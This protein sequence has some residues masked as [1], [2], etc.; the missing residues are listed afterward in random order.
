LTPHQIALIAIFAAFYVILSLITPIVLVAIGI[1]QLTISIEAFIASIFGLVLGP[2]LGFYAAFAGTSI[3]WILGGGSPYGL[4]FLLSPPFNALVTGFIYYRKW[5]QAFVILGILTAVFLFLPP[6][7]PFAEFWYISALV[8]W[9][10]II[11]LLLIIPT[12]KF[13]KRLSSTKLIPILYFL[14]GFI[15]NQAD[16]MWGTD[17]Y[18]I[19]VVYNGIFG[20]LIEAVRVGFTVSPLFYPAIRILQGIF[21]AIIAVPLLLRLRKSGWIW[22]EKTIID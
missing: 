22:Q 10:K 11:A 14:L 20:Q 8:V 15:G 16:N 18:A 7:Q 13:A 2:Y 6:S 1:P 4:P 21:V 17:I 3:A 5:K 9:D 19:P 12:V